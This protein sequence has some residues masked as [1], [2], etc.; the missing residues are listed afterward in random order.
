V[1]REIVELYDLMATTLELA[2]IEPN[3][4]HFA[5]CLMLQHHGVPGDPRRAAFC[6]GGYHRNEPQD[7]EPMEDFSEPSNINFPKIKLQNEHP[8]TITR[9]TMIRSSIRSKLRV[10]TARVSSTTTPQS[11]RT[12]YVYGESEFA[13]RQEE[14]RGRMLDWYVRTADVAPN[15]HDP[16]GFRKKP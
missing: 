14:L 2:R 6:E 3:H 15:Q 13:A 8:E 5:R 7:F 11:A 10:R 9:A 4:M 12:A 1:S 16:R